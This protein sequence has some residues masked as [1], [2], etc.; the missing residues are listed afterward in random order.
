ML[1]GLSLNFRPPYC[2]TWFDR[3]VVTGIS[4][5]Q[6][7]GKHCR[8]LAAQ[9]PLAPY[10]KRERTPPNEHVASQPTQSMN[11]RPALCM[12]A[13]MHPPMLTPLQ[14]AK[15][16]LAKYFDMEELLFDRI[17]ARLYNFLAPSPITLSPQA[18][19]TP[20]CIHAGCQGHACQELRYGRA[21]VC[22]SW[23]Q[24]EGVVC[25]VKPRAQGQQERSDSH[26][27]CLSMHRHVH[28]LCSWPV[29]VKEVLR[30]MYTVV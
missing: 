3:V 24:A 6:A 12:H 1:A 16:M 18:C 13:T 2:T 11:P 26:T 20:A 19:P 22:S 4:R 27:M 5:R 28:T 14:A 25:Q 23:R 9:C 29:G 17:R 30:Y 10:P 7:F 15:G 21:V 8:P